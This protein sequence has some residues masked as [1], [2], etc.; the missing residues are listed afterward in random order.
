M[1]GFLIGFFFGVFFGF[2]I[3]ACAVIA[4]GYND[5]DR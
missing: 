5:S 1:I 4:G 2:F 3:A